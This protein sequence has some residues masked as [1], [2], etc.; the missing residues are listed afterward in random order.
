[1]LLCAGS[2]AG[3]TKA[4]FNNV[5]MCASSKGTFLPHVYHA[6]HWDSIPPKIDGLNTLHCSHSES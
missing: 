6:Q 4:L 1:M 3:K 2:G 5:S